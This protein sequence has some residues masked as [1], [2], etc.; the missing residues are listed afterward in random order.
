MIR[1]VADEVFARLGPRAVLLKEKQLPKRF[2]PRRSHGHGALDAAREHLGA[3]RLPHLLCDPGGDA[4]RR[5]GVVLEWL[6]DSS[7]S[8]CYR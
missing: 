5:R 4:P 6:A 3:R 7:E 1:H 2:Y 8:L